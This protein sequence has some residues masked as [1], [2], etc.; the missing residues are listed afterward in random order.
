MTR[1]IMWAAGEWERG[2]TYTQ[3]LPL[4]T[5]Y[6]PGPKEIEKAKELLKQSRE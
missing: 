5:D 1:R 3:L 4:P 6:K 2:T